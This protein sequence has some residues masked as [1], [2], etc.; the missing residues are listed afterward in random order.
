MRCKIDWV[1]TL[2]FEPLPGGLLSEDE[3][4]QIEQM[5]RWQDEIDEVLSDIEQQTNEGLISNGV[6]WWA[7]RFL[8]NGCSLD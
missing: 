2:N 1:G 3:E 5:L 8:E 4:R 6:A 7:M